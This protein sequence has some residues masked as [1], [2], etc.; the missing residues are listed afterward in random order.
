[1]T[2]DLCGAGL[3]EAL[4]EADGSEEE[5]VETGSVGVEEDETGGEAG[6]EVSGE[7]GGE[8]TDGEVVFTPR[9]WAAVASM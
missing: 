8:V 6:G 5:S 2:R 3:V 9:A 4:I 7:A 1:M